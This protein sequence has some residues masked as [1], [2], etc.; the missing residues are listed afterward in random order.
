MEA[1]ML[2][3]NVYIRAIAGTVISLATYLFGV[4]DALL[5]ALIAM[6]CIDFASGMIKALVMKQ[7]SSQKMFVG[8]ARKLGMMMIVAV[9]NVIDNVLEMGGVLR[10]VTISYFI[11]NEGISMLENWSLMGLPIPARLRDVLGQLRDGGNKK[12]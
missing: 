7:V 9:A 1:E 10:A 12:D 2:L 8:G 5:W 3:E 11:A 4:P 6:I